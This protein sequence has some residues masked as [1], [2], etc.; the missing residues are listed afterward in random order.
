MRGVVGLVSGELGSAW[1]RG[2]CA[3]APP[4]RVALGAAVSPEKTFSPDPSAFVPFRFAARGQVSL[5]R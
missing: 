4:G 5:Y 1:L 2:V 3:V